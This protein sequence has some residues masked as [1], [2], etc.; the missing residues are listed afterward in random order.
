MVSGGVNFIV[1]K[2]L[3][4]HSRQRSLAPLVKYFVLAVT[5]AG[6]S[7]ISIRTLADFGMN[8]IA[9]KI[10]AES[11]LFFGSFAIQREFL[12]VEPTPGPEG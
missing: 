12:F 5:L 6:L 1:N 9:A 3:V 4:F 10:V 7:F 8:V 11:V 2:N